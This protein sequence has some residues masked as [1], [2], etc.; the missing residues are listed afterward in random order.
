VARALSARPL[1]LV[2]TVSYGAYLWH[3]PVNVVLTSARVHVR[4]AGLHALQFA[5]TFA[6]AAVSYRY[7]EKPIRQRGLPFGRALYVVPAAIALSVFLVVRG[8]H[9]RP[10]LD[11]LPV[12]PGESPRGDLSFHPAPLKI[13]VFGDSTANSLG[14]AIRGVR[15]PGVTVELLGKDSCTMLWDTCG[16][17]DWPRQVNDTHP[18]AV[19]VFFGGAFLHGITADGDWRKA[20]HPAWDAKFQSTVAER[21][22]G[23]HPSAGQVWAVTVPYPLGRYDSAP[24]RAEVDCINASLKKAVATAPHVRILDLGAWLCPGG[25]CKVEREGAEIR[26]DG[27]HYDLQAARDLG[28]WALD[29]LKP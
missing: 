4:G 3:W 25:V 29:Q 28:R 8:T 7:L 12:E 20:C 10:P 27:V 11:P 13:A 15:R 23:L 5:V 1:T 17:A 14:W 9:A 21:L 22:G 2:G 19:L 16:G 26:P 6:I 24:W 18:D